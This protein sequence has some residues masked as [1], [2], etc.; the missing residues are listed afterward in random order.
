M[1][2]QVAIP[3][4]IQQLDKLEARYQRWVEPINRTMRE[5]MFKVNRDGYTEADYDRDVRAV[6]NN[7]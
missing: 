3:D 7:S 1:S 4:L 2:A 5:C 6:G